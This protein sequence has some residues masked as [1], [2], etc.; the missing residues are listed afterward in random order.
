VTFTDSWG[1]TWTDS[2]EV[3]VVGTGA[4]MALAGTKY[5]ITEAANGNAD[6]KAN[7]RESHYLDI[8]VGN[9]GTSNVLAV[10]VVLSTTNE[11]VTLD[12]T[13]G[14]IGDVRAGYYQTLTNKAS[15]SSSTGTS[16]SSDSN[17]LNSSTYYPSAFKFTISETCP[18]GT[19]IPFTV[20]FTDSWGNTW[21]DAFEVPVAGTGASMALAGT[22]YKITEAA[23]GNADGKA[24]PHE[25]HYLDIM[26]RNTGTSNVLEV[27]AVL[28][29]TS[30]YVTL[31]KSTGAIGD[32]TAGYYK[33]LTDNTSSYSS[34]S[35]ADLL[36]SSYL[37]TK[38]FK[39]TMSATCPIGTN[40]P[41][42]VTFTDSWGNAW[43]DTFSIMVE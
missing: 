9:T 27:N 23:N 38:A 2:F 16:S 4:G 43:T 24:N 18:I 3:P 5:K 37:S 28:S 21:T 14:T 19:N 6:G 32:L 15:S 11:Y 34:A 25:S 20:T 30:G 29:T 8:M 1:N 39:F 36:Y 10:S 40:I 22:K 35:S 42:T 7:P 17:M 12:K 41:F 31:D 26:V 33:T 13:T